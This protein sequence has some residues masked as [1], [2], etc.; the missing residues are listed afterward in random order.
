MQSW[1]TIPTTNVTTNQIATELILIAYLLQFIPPSF[2]TA[3][4]SFPCIVVTPHPSVNLILPVI[5]SRN[6]AQ[7]MTTLLGLALSW[8]LHWIQTLPHITLSNLTTVLQNRF[9]HPKCHLSFPNHMTHHPTHPTSSLLSYVSTLKLHSNT[10]ASS[11]KGI[12]Q[13][14][15][16]GHFASATNH[17]SPRST[18]IVVFHYS[19]FHLL[20]T[21][22]APMEFSCPATPLPASFEISL[23]T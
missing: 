18:L 12:A 16:K 15:L 19:I 2:T 5:E 17:M 13:N 6:Q 9:L 8:I 23:P 21:T 4:Y 3:A 1:S 20:G 10:K 14:L 7:A 22:Y 11:M